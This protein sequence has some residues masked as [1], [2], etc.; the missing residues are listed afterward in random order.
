[1]ARTVLSLSG[2]RPEDIARFEPDFEVLDLPQASDPEAALQNHRTDIV[3]IF[4]NA[5]TPIRGTLIE[6]LPNLEIISQRGVGVDNI[7]WEAVRKRE[8]VVTNTPTVPS[9]DTA[10]LAFGLILVLARRI[11]ESDMFVR[12]GKWPRERPPTG[13]SLRGKTVG[14]VGLG[15][16]GQAVAVRAQTF[17]MNVLYTGPREKPDQPYMFES[18]LENLAERADFLVL[19]CPD[20]PGT[21]HL[22]GHD[23]LKAL[24]PSGYLVNVARGAVVDE[25]ALLIALRNREIAGAGLD[26]FE[27]EPHVP[28]AF[29]S[30]DNVALLPHIGYATRETRQ[31]MWELALENLL[32]YFRGE[33]VPSAVFAP[34]Y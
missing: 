14:I 18:N 5:L 19:C 7:D 17:G 29:F 32:A 6:A 34:E 25:E 10:D 31:A 23:I 28:E 4:C 1:M 12:V 15:H 2:I 21:R 13:V 24:G 30:M 3:A 22:I 26:V 11:V 33:P 16:I 9:E 27:N 8:I 20:V